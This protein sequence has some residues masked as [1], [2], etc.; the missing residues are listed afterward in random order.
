MHEFVELISS[1]PALRTDDDVCIRPL[2]EE[3][4]HP[5]DRYITVSKTHNQMFDVV[6]HCYTTSICVLSNK[7]FLFC[8]IRSHGRELQSETLKQRSSR[9]KEG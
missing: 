5:I 4:F 2:T 8:R 3:E 6:S 7:T 1:L 9:N